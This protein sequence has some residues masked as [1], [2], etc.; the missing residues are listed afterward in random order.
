MQAERECTKRALSTPE[1]LMYAKKAYLSLSRS[2]DKPIS[3]VCSD[4]RFACWLPS[5]SLLSLSFPLSLSPPLPLSLSPSL[6]FLSGTLR[7]TVVD[8]QSCTLLPVQVPPGHNISHVSGPM[9]M[10]SHFGVL[11]CHERCP[12]FR[13]VNLI[14][15]VKRAE[16]SS[17][18]DPFVGVDWP[19]GFGVSG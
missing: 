7:K 5:L 2:S 15:Q 1:L 14:A 18:R 10:T 12:C 6:C 19:L 8:L 13:L 3:R 4:C 17:F 9:I 11:R 16:E